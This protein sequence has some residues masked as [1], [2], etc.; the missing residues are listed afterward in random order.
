MVIQAE[1]Q[2]QPSDTR[3]R[4]KTLTFY[5][6]LLAVLYA[7]VAAVTVGVWLDPAQRQDPNLNGGSEWAIPILI[8]LCVVNVVALV[9]LL[10]W[11]KAGY[12]ALVVTAIPLALMMLL[13]HV[14]P[15]MALFPVFSA[16]TLWSVLQAKWAEF[17]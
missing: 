9:A 2:T 14:Q 4:G 12:T 3:T 5:L 6:G 10:N 15:L 13:F 1:H 11:R 7:F 16:G 17:Y 8:I